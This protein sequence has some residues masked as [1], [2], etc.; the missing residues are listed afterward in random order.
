MSIIL[1]K[2]PSLIEPTQTQ[3][4]VARGHASAPAAAHQRAHHAA[5]LHQ[6]DARAPAALWSL[7]FD[8]A[9]LA[10]GRVCALF[11]ESHAR[12]FRLARRADPRDGQED[13][14]PVGDRRHAA[15]AG[16]RE[17]RA[18]EKQGE[19]KIWQLGDVNNL[20]W[21]EYESSRQEG[22]DTSAPALPSI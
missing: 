11:D 4:L 6:A 1:P 9:R 15:R 7:L 20:D 5:A 3:Q 2:F 18:V 17:T 12:G 14:E 16:A 10:A 21:R 8:H 22:K 13:Q 19:R